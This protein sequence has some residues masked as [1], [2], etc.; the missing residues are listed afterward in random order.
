MQV[1]TRSNTT[2]SV[3][4]VVPTFNRPEALAACV[5][6]IVR[7]DYP[8]D[9]LE[10]IVVDDGSLMPVTVSGRESQHD[11][12]IRVLRQS[13]AGPA[14]ARN[15]GAQHARGDMLAFTDD[16]CMPAPQWLRELAHAF[17]GVPGKLIG[18]RTVNALVDNLYSSASQIIVDEAYAYFL[19]RESDLKFFASNN[20]AMSAEHFHENGGFDP[21]FRTAEDRDFCDRWIRRG[22]LVEYAPEAIVYHQHRLTL[23]AFWRQHFNY[24]RGAYRFHRVRAQRS[25]SRL[26]PDLRFYASVC[27][28]SLFTPFSWKSVGMA[29]LLGVWQAAN[30]AGFLS[31]GV[32]RDPPSLRLT[33]DDQWLRT[34]GSRL[35]AV[36]RDERQE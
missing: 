11:V 28:R 30:L 1:R 13:N 33:R 19:S 22:H 3:S 17:H 7:Q 20:M 24:G 31:Q 5:Q 14:S 9:R 6:A 29:G 4:V 36:N 18:G 26:R 27:R 32:C 12:P 25:G 34:S 15:L 8:R 10:V 16:D 2:P 35:T 21:S 23:A